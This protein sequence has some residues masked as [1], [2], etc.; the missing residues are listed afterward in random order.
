MS[1]NKETTIKQRYVRIIIISLIVLACFLL[2][3][4]CFLKQNDELWLS[5]A[6]NLLLN[7]SASIAITA[8]FIYVS[9]E[10]LIRYRLHDSLDNLK[11]MIGRIKWLIYGIYN[12]PQYHKVNFFHELIDYPRYKKVDLN[13]IECN[14]PKIYK[15]LVDFQMCLHEYI[16]EILK[17]SD[18]YDISKSGEFVNV[19]FSNGIRIN[20]TIED[21]T[22]NLVESCHKLEK[23]LY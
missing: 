18:H 6:S 14:E 3:Y 21:L 11:N 2:S 8:L 4:V 23:L 13:I 9:E 10:R 16:A 1:V 20:E 17:Q 22:K 12:V 19:S 15:Q 5:W 7:I